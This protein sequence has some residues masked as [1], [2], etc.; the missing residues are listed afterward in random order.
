MEVIMKRKVLWRK[1]HHKNRTRWHASHR[2]TIQRRCHDCTTPP[3]ATVFARR[4]ELVLAQKIT[5]TNIMP[6]NREEFLFILKFSYMTLR[7]LGADGMPIGSCSG[8]IVRY[9]GMRFLLTAEHSVGDGGLWAIEVDF[10]QGGWTPRS[11]TQWGKCI[12]LDWAVSVMV[13]I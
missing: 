11:S 7:K 3:P 6:L 1:S 9:G 8:C 2:G 4:R 13:S 5:L 12:F 10:D